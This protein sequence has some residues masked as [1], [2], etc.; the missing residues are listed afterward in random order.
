MVT[1][2][3]TRQDGRVPKD[4]EE[5]AEFWYQ[6][7][8][9]H[10]ESFTKARKLCEAVINHATV[11]FELKKEKLLQEVLND[12]VLLRDSEGNTYSRP[13]VPI[14]LYEPIQIKNIIGA[15]KICIAGERQAVKLQYDDR[16]V[17]IQTVQQMGFI[18]QLDDGTIDI[19]ASVI[20]MENP[21]D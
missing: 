3:L 15:L 8:G 9:E 17:A 18:L 4:P 11:Q 10:F 12:G 16:A 21:P 5:L 7:S 20:E 13:E 1:G 14:Q 6:L 19:D 2:N